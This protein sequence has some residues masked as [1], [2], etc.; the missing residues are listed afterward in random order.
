MRRHRFSGDGWRG[1][2]HQLFTAVATIAFACCVLLVARISSAQQG[3]GEVPERIQWTVGPA[4]ADLGGVARLQV[5]TGYRFT[6]VPGSKLWMELTNNPYE[7]E[8]GVLIPP[9]NEHAGELPAW[10]I[11]FSYEAI[12]H[13]KDDEKDEL[14]GEAA[15]AMLQVIREAT[16]RGNQERRSRGW[17]GLTVLGWHQ[18]PHYDPA[19][20]NLTWAMRAS[21]GAGTTVNYDSRVLGRRGV[22]TVKMVLGEEQVAAAVPA[23]RMVVGGLTFKAG[24]T[25]AEFRSGDKV[26]QYGLVGLVTGGSAV[27]AV[28]W[29]KPLVKF[30]A[31]LV[32]VL[33][34]LGRKIASLFGIKGAPQVATVGADG[35]AAAA[36]QTVDPDEPASDTPVLVPCPSCKRMNRVPNSRL[37][38]RPKCGSCGSPLMRGRQ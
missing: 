27:A 28:K 13:V 1:R 24:E 17:P 36:E 8:L 7:G 32:A 10:Y 26:A 38:D 21:D 15:A 22:M 3:R 34:V 30:G 6:G 37:H 14:G 19:T 11:V 25:H 31:V 4:E 5:P 23:Y 9:F 20:R 18:T 12:G 2:V 35:S 16:E 33:A 29:W